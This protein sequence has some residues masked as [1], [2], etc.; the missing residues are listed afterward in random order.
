MK[1]TTLTIPAVA[2]V[3]LAAAPLVAEE[4]TVETVVDGLYNPSAV[5]VQPETGHIFV[6]DSGAGRVIRVVD[7][8][9]QDVIVG[10][11]KDVY[12][13]GPMFD[14]G[15]LGLVFLNK[16]TLVVGG[17]DKPDGEELL[18]V[19]TVPA[20]GSPAIKAT[21]T[22]VSF[23]MPAT[24][25][26]KGE[27][28]FYGL[29]ATKKAIFVTCNGDDTKGWVSR[30]SIVNGEVTDFKRFLAT[31]EA[32]D[33]DAPIAAAISPKGQLVVGQGGEVTVPQD[34]LLTFYNPKN[35]KLLLNLP[36]GLYDITGLAYSAD[37]KKI[38]ATDFAWMKTSEGGLFQLISTDGNGKQ[39]IETKKL[40]S[41]DKPTA[42]AIVGDVAYV[43]VFGTPA[44]GSDGKS[45]KL[46]KITLK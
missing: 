17:G 10:F 4:P 11:G 15:P 3:L 32:T 30:A 43:T 37:G 8:E 46:V 35:G 45:G 36:T 23:D 44:E 13:K 19:F 27:G 12:G 1:T 9:A 42:L 21:D 34:S 40:A 33:V 18:R 39:K 38:F 2:L 20:A 25:D 28:N 7:G 22:V 5:A 24:D 29:A 16:D 31:K 26:V 41:L 6:S 14:I